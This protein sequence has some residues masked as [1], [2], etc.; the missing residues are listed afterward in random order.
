[1]NELTQYT[2]TKTVNAIP[3]TRGEYNKLRGWQIPD[4]ENPNE[5]GFL[6]EYPDGGTPNHVAFKGYISWSPADVFERAYRS[7]ETF[8]DRLKNEFEDNAKRLEGLRKFL[9]TEP[10]TPVGEKERDL[11]FRQHD[12]M[13]AYDAVLRARLQI[14][15]VE[16]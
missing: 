3:M 1:M 2:G 4:D 11:L 13:G 10:Y 14:H 5:D 12:A 8:I 7:S 16:V 15:G 9:K 6:V